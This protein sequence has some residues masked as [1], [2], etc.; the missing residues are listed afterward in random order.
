MKPFVL[1]SAFAVLMSGAAVAQT[2]PA[3]PAP[4]SDPAVNTN[5]STPE[6]SPAEGLA[7]EGTTPAPEAPA[8]SA[9]VTPGS[10]AAAPEAMGVEGGSPIVTLPEVQAGAAAAHFLADDLEGEDVYG[11]MNE[12]IGDVSDIVLAADGTVAAIVIE[13]G[14]FLGIGQKDVLV[15]WNAVEIVSEGDDDLRI[16]APTLTREMLE[17]AEGVDLDTLLI[18]R[19]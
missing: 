17:Q 3:A 2:T 11:S 13:V 5:P 14:G 8:G 6:P 1:A 18:G 16:L 12:E 4:G 7:P 9:P 19:N 15:D 10:E